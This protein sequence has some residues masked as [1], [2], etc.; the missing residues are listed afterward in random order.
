V[1]FEIDAP[2][3]GVV[4]VRGRLDAEAADGAA[5]R[6]RTFSGPLTVD[7]A[8]LDYISSA[9]I[10]VMME[11]Y[12]RLLGAGQAMKLVQ[13]NPRVRKIFMYAG[14]DRILGIE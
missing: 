5:A 7:C 12:K 14:L 2:E 3:P 13:V 4:H 11:T 10:S 8:E 1:K 9:G 6:F